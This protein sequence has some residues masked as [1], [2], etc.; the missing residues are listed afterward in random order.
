MCI[1]VV[2]IVKRSLVSAFLKVFGSKL[3]SL[4]LYG[5][6]ARCEPRPDSDIDVLVVLEKLLEDRF[7][8]H[9]LLDEVE[10]N[11]IEAFEKLGEL[12][13]TPV[14]SPIIL[15]RERAMRFR[16]LYIDIV[17]DAVIL[18]DKDFFMKS[19]LEKVR[20]KLEALGARRV[21]IGKKWIVDIKPDYRF[22]EIIDLSL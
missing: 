20:R 2:E 5:S 16:P 4:V 3:V 8:L 11:L 12:G 7:Q 21:K 1:E 15:D 18:Y 6:Y 9:V 10:K 17:F 19:I 22:G 14:L 13:Y